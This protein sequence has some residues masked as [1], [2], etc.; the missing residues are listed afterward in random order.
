MLRDRYGVRPGDRV[1][2][3]AAN[4]PEWIVTFWATVALD[5]IAVGLNAWWTAD[6]ILYALSDCEPKVL[7]ADV[8]RLARLEAT[9]STFPRSRWRRDFES[10]WSAYPDA[11]LPSDPIGAEDRV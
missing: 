8:K 7:V 3:L 1:A 10:V 4:S 2:I 6:E 9:R 5:A 11:T